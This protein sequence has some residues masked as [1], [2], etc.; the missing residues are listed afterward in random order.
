MIWCSPLLNAISVQGFG[1]LLRSCQYF[2]QM[3]KVKQ[4]MAPVYKKTVKKTKRNITFN[5]LEKRY[6]STW[7]VTPTHYAVFEVQ[8]VYQFL[9]DEWKS[10]LHRENYND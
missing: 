10:F 8:C 4:R 3:K 7:I 9:Y 1:P 5:S 6:V 2:L